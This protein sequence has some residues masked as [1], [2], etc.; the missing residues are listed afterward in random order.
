MATN[1]INQLNLKSYGTGKA[2]FYYLPDV[3][4]LLKMENDA[5]IQISMRK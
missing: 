2:T 4:D 5:Q 1:I 3:E